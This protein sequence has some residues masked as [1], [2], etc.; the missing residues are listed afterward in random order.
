V[1]PEVWQGKKDLTPS[2]DLF[3][4]GCMLYELV[5]LRRLFN[6]TPA[7]IVLQMKGRSA[8]EEAAEVAAIS[9]ALA[10]IFERLVHRTPAHRYGSA[11]ELID[12]LTAVRDERGAE[13]DVDEFVSTVAKRLAATDLDESLNLRLQD[14]LDPRWAALATPSVRPLR[15]PE[16]P[17]PAPAERRQVALVAAAIAAI[18]LVGVV[19]LMVVALR[20][21]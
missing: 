1:P 20:G 17:V 11:A 7:E 12:D 21:G 3:A 4:L 15:P 9:P 8:Q 18:G 5:T 6:G 10:P 19:A 14:A 13:A 2:S 16:A